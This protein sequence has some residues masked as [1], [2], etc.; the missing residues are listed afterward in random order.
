MQPFGYTYVFLHAELKTQT[1]KD[2]SKFVSNI[3]ITSVDPPY[4]LS[5]S[6]I[7]YS[8][9]FYLFSHLSLSFFSIYIYLLNIDWT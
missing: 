2:T 5:V 7:G 4:F 8:L 9:S 6:F 1:R 3:L